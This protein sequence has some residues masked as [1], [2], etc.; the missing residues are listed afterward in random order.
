MLLET[1]EDVDQNDQV[2]SSPVFV[3]LM[4]VDSYILFLLL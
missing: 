1:G 2:L 3:N 4:L